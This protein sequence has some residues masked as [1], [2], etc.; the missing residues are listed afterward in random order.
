MHRN[1]FLKQAAEKLGFDPPANCLQRAI[2]SGAIPTPERFGREYC[3]TDAH[4]EPF[5]AYMKT[6]SYIGRRLSQAVGS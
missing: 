6:R 2:D 3:F 4:L 1:D 5:I